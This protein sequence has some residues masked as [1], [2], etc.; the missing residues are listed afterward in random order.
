MEPSLKTFARQADRLY[1]RGVA[2]AKG[3]QRTVAA[4][5]LRQAV[6]LNPQH[7][8]AWLWL[9]GVLDKPE[10]IAFCLRAALDLNPANERARLGLTEVEARSTQKRVLV[11]RRPLVRL[12]EPAPP[13]PWWS[14]WREGRRAWRSM[15]RVLWLIPSVLLLLTLGVRSIILSQPLPAQAFTYRDLPAAVPASARPIP[16]LVVPSPVPAP[17]PGIVTAYFAEVRAAEGR[18]NAATNV[19]RQA[20]QGSTTDLE[21]AAA[22]RTFRETIARE[23]GILLALIPLPSLQPPHATYLEGLQ[24]EQ[25]AL[26][27]LLKFYGNADPVLATRAGLG[28]Q[29]AR[30]KIDEGKQRWDSFAR[31]YNH[32]PE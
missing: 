30:S 10:E 2:A 26:D 8:H 11:R 18:L 12:S 27:D 7:E 23:R 21:R 29:N 16:T 28:L 15:V 31:Q 1:E 32:P 14:A 13:E 9:S 6:R 20:T 3:G 22:T 4:G 24:L 19:Y 25:Q 5:L 17:D